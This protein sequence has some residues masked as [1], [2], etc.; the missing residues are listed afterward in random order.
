MIA[1]SYHL[2]KSLETLLLLKNYQD[3]FEIESLVIRSAK[4]ELL[5]NH[6]LKDYML[7]GDYVYVCQSDDGYNLE[8]CGYEFEI[9]TKD[10]AITSYKVTF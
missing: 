2:S 5:Q 6:E 7:D 1:F 8:Y 4:C 10:D 3:N 9:E